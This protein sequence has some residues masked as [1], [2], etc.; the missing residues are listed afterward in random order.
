MKSLYTKIVSNRNVKLPEKIPVFDL[1]NLTGQSN[2]AIGNGVIVHNCAKNKKDDVTNEE[3]LN[4]FAMLGLDPKHEDPIA[5]LRVGKVILM[6]DS[7]ADGPLHGSTLVNV[8]SEGWMKMRDV[9]DKFELSTFQVYSLTADGYRVPTKARFPTLTNSSCN[10]VTLTTSD[11]QTLRCTRNH[12]WPVLG[13]GIPSHVEQE[14]RFGYN[15]IAAENL[16]TGMKLYSW[17]K[18][19]VFS[20]ST[21][22]SVSLVHTVEPEDFYCLSSDL[23]NFQIRSH[24]GGLRSTSYFTGN[25]H[26]ATLL[27]AILQKYVPQM[28]E[29]GMVY[30]TRVPEYYAISGKN[31]YYGAT[32]TEVSDALTKDG[33]KAEV[34][35]LKGYGECPSSLLKLFACD[36]STRLLS[37]IS[38]ASDDRFELLMSSDTSSRKL[39]LG[40]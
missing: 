7:D 36:P 4:I 5:N 1:E 34:N 33:A 25:C 29:R 24:T 40:I 3:T 9:A 23:G 2:F 12:K 32:A 22:T 39:L 28:F 26:I 13:E 38:P 19:N 11:G 10:T 21:I 6:P 14:H 37:R 17:G 31:L 16:S 30:V 18:G 27:C 35:H 15:Y 8:V 20:T